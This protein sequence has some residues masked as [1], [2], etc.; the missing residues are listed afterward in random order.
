MTEMID[1]LL[2]DAKERM[3][4]SVESTN[5]EFGTVRTGRAS[6]ALLDRVVVDYYGAETPLN[7]LATI[8]A[9]E[10]QL[11]S[12]QPYDVSSIK[13]LEKAIMESGIGLTPNNDG[14]IIRLAIP[15]LNEERRREM[16]KLV[17]NI[18]EEGR[19]AVRNV[20]RDVMHD[21]REL[22][23]AGEAGADDEHRAEVELQKLTDAA[24]ADLDA[25]LK[26]K[27]DEI[28]EV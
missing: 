3:H 12:V 28:T 10:P 22:R 13:M 7:Q 2:A 11:L 19:I 14:K 9:P 17:R 6:P 24:I 5:H 20:R 27:E 25:H 4:K 1:E 26:G 21:L 8:S 23:D 18:A 16:V 15:Q